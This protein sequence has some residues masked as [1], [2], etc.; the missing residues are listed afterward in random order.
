SVSV[1]LSNSRTLAS[2]STIMTVIVRA[3]GGITLPGACGAYARQGDS[4]TAESPFE[5]LD[6]HSEANVEWREPR[7]ADQLLR[8]RRRER[9]APLLAGLGRAVLGGLLHADDPGEVIVD[10]VDRPLDSGADVHCAGGARM[11]GSAH[12]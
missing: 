11:L 9:A 4:S 2:S 12:D 3:A 5:I 10:G 8:S 6:R 1:S 7:P